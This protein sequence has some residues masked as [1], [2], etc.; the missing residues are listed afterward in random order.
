MKTLRLFLACA[1]LS[2]FHFPPASVF[3]Q[4]TAFT[5]QGVLSQ[6]GAAVNGSNDLTFTLY[7][8]VSGGGTV[9]TSNVVNDLV[10]S[11]GLF[12]VTLDFGA[13]AFDGSAR[14]LQIAARPGASTGGY[15]N[16]APRTPIT[17]TPYAVFANTASNLSGA[18]PAAAL[19]GTYGSAVTFNNAANQFSGIGSNLTA[20]NASQLASG[21]VPAA[22]LGNAWRTAGNSNTT[23]GTHFLGTTDNQPLDFRVNN[24]RGLRLEYQ[25]SVFSESVNVIGGYRSNQ[26][27]AGIVGA[28]ISGGGAL[29]IGGSA[30]NRVT[31]D[32]GTVGG[33]TLN[34]ASGGFAATVGGGQQNTASGDYATVPGGFANTA[35]N[36]AFS[37]GNRAKANHQG[38]FVWADSTTADFASTANNQF[39]IRATGGVGINVNN[40]GPDALLVNGT[41]RITGGLRGNV[42]I[43]TAT[44]SNLLDVAAGGVIGN[45]TVVGANLHDALNRGTKVSF[46]YNIPGTEFNGMRAVVNPGTSICGNS[47][48]LLFYT[49]EC[50]TSGSREVMRINGTGNVGIG[51][52]TPGTTLDVRSD[53]AEITVGTI[54]NTDGALY[55]GNP[56]HGVKRAYSGG[57]DVGLYTT[58][59]DVYLSANGTTTSQFVLKNN[60]NVGI[61]TSS[62]SEKLHVAGNVFASGTILASGNLGIGTSNPM[63]AIGYPGGWDGLHARSPGGSGLAIIQG[64][65][66]ARLHLRA[67][68]NITNVAQDFIMANGANRIDFTWLGSGLG[69]RLLAMT[70]A[71]NGNVGI[72][73]EVTTTAVNITSDRNAK[74]QFKPVNAREVL[75]KVAALP[76][77]EWQYKTQGDAR[78]IGPMA[79]DFRAAFGVGHD[80]KHITSVDADGVALAAIQGL[81][82]VVREQRESIE[83][84]EA[85]NRDLEMRLAGR[86]AVLEKLMEQSLRQERP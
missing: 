43:G 84:L 7:N 35:T 78:H 39:L 9:G 25:N 70:I 29:N 67:D 15:T 4:G 54:F 62:P 44:P 86:L 16:L 20:L 51:T 5:Y 58:A 40:P 56:G 69:T 10:M 59:A 2:A 45:S 33:G 27:S 34:T 60:G 82:E 11:N 50:N 63:G 18:L 55:F 3:A 14:W 22:A 85:R 38:T 32:F 1:A 71:T 79:Q 68:N 76:I 21:T 49:W 53:T 57:N 17:A 61:G 65:S 80:E 75:D 6:G 23:P 73:G 72:A 8:A 46:G 24:Q 30:P 37:A 26:V 66:T 47:G 81:N 48:D 42:G 36:Y 64:A 13:G 31:G 77:T 83:N 52:Q 74:E 12:T 28:T 19:S 41:A